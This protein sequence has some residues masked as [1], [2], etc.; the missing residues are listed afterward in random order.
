MQWQQ[1]EYKISTDKTLLDIDVIYHYLSQEAY[2]CKG[3]PQAT[4]QK[5]I[6]NSLCFGLYQQNVQIGFAR[7]ITDHATFAYLSDVFVLPEYRGNGLS[8]WLMQCIFVH[9]ELQDLR[10]IML[11]TAD[12]HGLYSQFDFQAL[13]HPER[14]MQIVNADIYQ[15]S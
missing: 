1:Q 4:V 13:D 8:K 11:A 6:D 2:W 7:M 10:R 5:A 9:P 14:F 15:I 3:I 12:A